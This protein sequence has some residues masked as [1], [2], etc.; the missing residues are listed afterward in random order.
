MQMNYANFL[1][2]DKGTQF[3]K[4]MGVALHKPN[5]VP[6]TLYE[7]PGLKAPG[8]EKPSFQNRVPLTLIEAPGLK[9]P[10][11]LS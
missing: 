4:P 1:A 8:F 3:P 10:G 5:W 11:F 6:L 7:A 2:I 9:A